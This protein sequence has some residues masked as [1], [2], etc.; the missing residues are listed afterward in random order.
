M[1]FNTCRQILEN[2]NCYNKLMLNV[3]IKD[4]QI[5]NEISSLKND[6][7]DNCNEITIIK[8]DNLDK[9]KILFENYLY[10]TTF[11]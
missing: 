2:I 6:I 7:L 10:K 9:L 1:I 3:K 8:N 11:I 5:M 4:L